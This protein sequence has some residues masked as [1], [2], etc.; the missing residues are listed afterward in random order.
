MDFD[1]W[2]CV[3]VAGE[4]G[5][6]PDK[7]QIALKLAAC[8]MR[9]EKRDQMLFKGE[10]CNGFLVTGWNSFMIGARS[11]ILFRSE[12]D[13]EG[14]SIKVNFLLSEA[15]LKQGAKR[16]KRMYKQGRITSIARVGQIELPALRD[17]SSLR[18]GGSS[19]R[20]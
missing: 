4:F 13:V 7:V 19:A 3:M 10:D 12:V 15:D 8:D 1:S 20:H 11:G 9:I 14:K 16:L 6:I 2:T 5:V 18:A 17:F